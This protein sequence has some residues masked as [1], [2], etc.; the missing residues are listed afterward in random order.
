MQAQHNQ[1]KNYGHKLWDFI[2]YIYVSNKKYRNLKD[3]R[4]SSSWTV[5]KLE[6][7]VNSQ[8]TRE[9]V[10]PR[11]Q[12]WPLD[13][14]QW[15]ITPHPQ[16]S[17]KII[18]LYAFRTHRPIKSKFPSHINS[19]YLSDIYEEIIHHFSH[20]GFVLWHKRLCYRDGLETVDLQH[21]D[22]KSF[23]SQ[24]G[25]LTKCWLNVGQRRRR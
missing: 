19:I 15:H 20:V 12:Q 25:T 22:S 23:P 1:A 7:E 4:N 5:W 14:P 24:H 11:M 6:G 13:I 10:V 3:S 17:A 9:N 16:L 2:L 18:L 8:N 21:I